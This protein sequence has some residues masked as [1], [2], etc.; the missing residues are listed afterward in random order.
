[1]ASEMPP[2]MKWETGT[3][4][5]VDD[6]LYVVFVE[7]RYGTS[8]DLGWRTLFDGKIG[9]RTGTGGMSICDSKR[10]ADDWRITRWAKIT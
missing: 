5:P 1:M 7:S 6:L 4:P 8:K 9:W 3:P 10:Y 2:D